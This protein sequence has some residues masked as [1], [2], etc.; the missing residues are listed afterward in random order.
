MFTNLWKLFV[1]RRKVT[2]E[3]ADITDLV[4]SWKTLDK[5]EFN[6]HLEEYYNSKG[7]DEPKTR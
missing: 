4:R 1:P 2:M 5:T 6:H 7:I 3:F